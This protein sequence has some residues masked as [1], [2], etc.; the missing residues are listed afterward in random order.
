[1]SRDSRT[2]TTYRGGFCTTPRSS[3][4]FFT[5]EKTLFG[6]LELQIRGAVYRLAQKND[7]RDGFR[8]IFTEIRHEL[9][10]LEA[11]TDMRHVSRANFHLNPTCGL[12]CHLARKF[13]HGADRAQIFSC[14]R[15][16]K[17]FSH[18]KSCRAY[19]FFPACRLWSNQ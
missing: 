5:F 16:T 1:M 9:T 10:V 2:S 8:G 17:C 6:S 7:M 13:R 18:K 3:F 11:K 12:G 15:L 19:I 14:K 4:V